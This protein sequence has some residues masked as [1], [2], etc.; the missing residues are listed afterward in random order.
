LALTSISASEPTD[1]DLDRRLPAV[2]QQVVD[3]RRRMRIDAEQHVA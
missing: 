3:L 1:L 2:R